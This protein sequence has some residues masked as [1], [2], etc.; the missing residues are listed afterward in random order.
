MSV[1]YAQFSTLVSRTA[2]AGIGVMG[3]GIML[4]ALI[5]IIGA[6]R[7]NGK[8]LAVFQ[9]LALLVFLGQLLFAILVV[10]W[11]GNLDNVEAEAVARTDPNGVAAESSGGDNYL[12]AFQSGVSGAV[13]NAYK[14][15]CTPQELIDLRNGSCTSALEGSGTQTLTLTDPSS[16]GFC[17]LVTGSDTQVEPADGICPALNSAGA[18]SLSECR[19]AF[20]PGGVEAFLNFIHGI[21]QWAKDRM[22]MFAGVL[23]IFAMLQIVQFH[24]V[25]VLRASTR[26]SKPRAAP[27]RGPG[28]GGTQ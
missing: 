5:G 17:S 9:Y 27:D 23:G 4:I 28:A 1:N 21:L 18:I 12:A 7:R 3:G 26:V 24:N 11:I 19:A 15:C 10:F 8:I 2:T 14:L 22:G 6:W 13:C 16:P 20:C 25:S